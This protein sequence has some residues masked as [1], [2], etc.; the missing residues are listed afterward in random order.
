MH[1]ASQLFV[2][3]FEAK[4]DGEAAGHT[5]VFPDWSEL[6]RFGIVV[7]APFGG[8]GASLLT[9]LAIAT[10]YEVKPGRRK[11]TPAYPEIYLFHIGGPYGDFSNFDFW[12][13]RKEVLLTAN[14][15]L[16]VLETLNN[17]G[18]TRLA[19]PAGPNGDTGVFSQGPSTWA[20]VG[21]ARERLR[22]CFAYSESGL[23]PDGNVTLTS[24]S[25]RLFENIE[26]TQDPMPAVR[27]LRLR[28]VA[29][30][31]GED[32]A[33]PEEDELRYAQRAELRYA[34][35]GLDARNEIQTQFRHSV[36]GQSGRLRESY[37]M[38]STE[39]ALARIAQL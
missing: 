22:S 2:D 8:L 27:D 9:Q 5:E 13:P 14:E 38:I 26:A 18:I 35:V 33:R 17:Y 29:H 15:P 6:D 1:V 24:L 21:A 31:R 28:E 19:L 7:A 36:E 39:T 23:V 20:E 12:P 30:D 32:V 4:L 34:E 37:R 25:K 16:L 3:Q 10:F 11:E